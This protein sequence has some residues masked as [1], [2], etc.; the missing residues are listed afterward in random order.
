MI[1]QSTLDKTIQ[2]PICVQTPCLIIRH[3]NQVKKHLIAI[4]YEYRVL[5]NFSF[6]LGEKKKPFFGRKTEKPFFS[7]YYGSHAQFVMHMWFMVQKWYAVTL[8]WSS[9]YDDSIAL[10]RSSYH[11][12][13]TFVAPFVIPSVVYIGEKAL[14]GWPLDLSV[15]HHCQ[16]MERLQTQRI[17][18]SSVSRA[19]A[20]MP[21]VCVA[22]LL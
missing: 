22:W 7:V 18:F 1:G 19:L 16:H 17:L 4:Y 8:V 6:F 5:W 3:K 20:L 15:S 10:G 12:F 13:C 21:L 9:G 11:E 2:T 14:N